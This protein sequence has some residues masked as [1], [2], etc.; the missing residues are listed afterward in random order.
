MDAYR[1]GFMSGFLGVLLLLVVVMLLKRKRESDAAYD[2]RQAAIRG[3]GYKY[4][5][6]T[7]GLLT[8]VYAICFE[9]IA[10][11]FI[12]PGLV[13]VAI[14]FLSGLV[15]SGYCIFK[16]AYWGYKQHGHK[17]MIVCWGAL[18]VLFLAQ[19]ISKIIDGKVIENGRI[20]FDGGLP[21]VLAAFFLVF[22]CMQG[23]KLIIDKR[24]A[25]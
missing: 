22:L 19:A 5:Y 18:D 24:D 16:D 20:S 4:A 13:L 23:L 12:E 8:F 25:E 21:F 1:I 7:A 6:V 9:G 3:R 10:K 14:F 2:E 11:R 15:L 17:S